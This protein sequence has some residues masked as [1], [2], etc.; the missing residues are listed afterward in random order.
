MTLKSLFNITEVSKLKIWSEKKRKVVKKQV[1][2][3]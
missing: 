2:E 1:S 3:N